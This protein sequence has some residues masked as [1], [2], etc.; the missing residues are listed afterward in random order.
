MAGMFGDQI[1]TRA[2]FFEQLKRAEQ[3]C[4]RLQ[5]RLPFED[6]LA[7]IATQLDAISRWTSKARTPT[8]E[9]RKSID[10]GSRMFREYEM[11]DDDDVRRLRSVV[12]GIDTYI[13]FWPDDRTA[14]D[15]N[16]INYLFFSDL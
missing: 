13:K 12:S 4:R 3:D 6:T 15:P 16:N 14:G 10:M 7:S 2:E 11:T 8:L 1:N 9:E 5:S